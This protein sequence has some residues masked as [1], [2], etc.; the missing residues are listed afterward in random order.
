MRIARRTTTSQLPTYSASTLYGICGNY[1]CVVICPHRATPPSATLLVCQ[2]P[3]S[4]L[5]NTISQDREFVGLDLPKLRFGAWGNAA[6]Q[7]TAIRAAN[8]LDYT[9]E[10]H[11]T[12]DCPA[13]RFELISGL[14]P[15]KSRFS[16]PTSPNF[17]LY[18]KDE[19]AAVHNTDLDTV[20]RSGD[21]I[22]GSTTAM[23]Q[24]RFVDRPFQ[25][26]VKR[27]AAR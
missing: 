11:G 4:W 2:S 1:K 24:T 13:P 21:I 12:L 6:E 10:R 15:Q 14:Q 8:I 20:W 23:L 5:A 3:S 9:D 26:G 27:S 18:A 17:Y 25:S 16:S 7:S 19:G 22:F